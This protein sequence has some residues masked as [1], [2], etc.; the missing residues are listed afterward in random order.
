MIKF[1]NYSGWLLVDIYAVDNSV[2]S[3]Y[4]VDIASAEVIDKSWRHGTKINIAWA[5]NDI[6]VLIDWK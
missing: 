3:D 1:S 5:E 2:S 4:K 6:I